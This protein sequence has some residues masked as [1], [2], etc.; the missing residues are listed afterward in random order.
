MKH[1]ETASD[2]SVDNRNTSSHPLVA[3][4]VDALSWLENVK[5]SVAT[6][7][8]RDLQ[9]RRGHSRGS[10]RVKINTISNGSGT[11]KRTTS[12]LIR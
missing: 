6:R 2:G 11:A 3:A 5:V 7:A 10:F 12:R 1:S 8:V 9:A 4:N